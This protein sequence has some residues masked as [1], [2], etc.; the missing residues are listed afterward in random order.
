MQS[1]LRAEID[2]TLMTNPNKV[3]INIKSVPN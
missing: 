2:L 3:S 1:D